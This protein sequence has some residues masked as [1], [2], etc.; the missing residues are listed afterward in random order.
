MRHQL[1]EADD[2]TTVSAGAGDEIEV[3]LQGM[4]SSGYR[5]L[6]DDPP[7]NILEPLDQDFAF[8]EGSVGGRSA[9]RFRF[10]VKA[11]G[12]GNLRLRYARSWEKGEP[13]LKTWQAT[14]EAV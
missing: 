14:I 11:A 9:A 13:P 12:R 5:W 6:P 7:D 4:P 10:R 2:G 8:H 1:S 3:C